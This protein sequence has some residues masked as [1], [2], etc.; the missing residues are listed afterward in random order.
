MR[1]LQVRTR[2]QAVIRAIAAG[3]LKAGTPKMA[4]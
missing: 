2:G 3:E 4:E 1:K